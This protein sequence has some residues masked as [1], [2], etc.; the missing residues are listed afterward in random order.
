[1]DLE[2]NFSLALALIVDLPKKTE[3]AAQYSLSR[4]HEERES[5]FPAS[6]V[7]IS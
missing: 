7:L 5:A 3:T 4:N 6:V 2:C 1:M